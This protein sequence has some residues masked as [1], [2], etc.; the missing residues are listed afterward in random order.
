MITKE[1]FALLEWA[2]GSLGLKRIK[3]KTTVS[4][5]YYVLTPV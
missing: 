4:E 5:I 3:P 1:I 2:K